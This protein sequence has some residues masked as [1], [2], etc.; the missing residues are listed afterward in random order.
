MTGLKKLVTEYEAKQYPTRHGMYKRML[1]LLA[2]E[3]HNQSNSEPLKD[4]AKRKGAKLIHNNNYALL[5]RLNS[6]MPDKR[7]NLFHHESEVRQ[8]L[9]QLPDVAGGN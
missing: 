7:D 2:E 3:E 1:E 8:Y 9:E 4:L 5:F 6:D